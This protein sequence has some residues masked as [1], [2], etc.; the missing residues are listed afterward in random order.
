MALPPNIPTSFVP[1]QPVTTQSRRSGGRHGILY[2]GALFLLGVSVVGAGLTFGYKTYVETVRDSRKA[3]LEAAEKS[4]NPDAVEDFIRLR[5][6]IRAAST[7]LDQHVVTS[8]FFDVLET[9]TLQNVRFQSLILSVGPDRTA[10]IE[11]H[12][13]ARSFNALAAESA[14]F[15]AEKRIK[16]AIFSNITADK[17]GVVS[18][19]LRAELDPKLVTVTSSG[20]KVQ[21][22]APNIATSTPFAPVATTTSQAA[23]V[24]TATTTQVK[25]ATATTTT[26]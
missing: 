18:F 24:P 6:R 16:R 11:M 2:Y 15:A 1:K 5:N 17:N 4:I 14:A 9:L 20:I 10:K 13:V 26:P 12:G 23:K 8:Q 3:K 25:K 19:S 7:L 21:E 22:S